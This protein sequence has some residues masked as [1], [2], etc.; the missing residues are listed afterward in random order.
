MI[1]IIKVLILLPIL[2]IGSGCATPT[3]F[4]PFCLEDYPRLEDVTVEEQLS[5]RDIDP[6]LLRRLGEN[7]MK[8]KLYIKEVGLLADAHNEQFEA[9]CIN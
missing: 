2:M 1:K 9:E 5:I 7:N 8:L 3:Y 6:D 4:Q